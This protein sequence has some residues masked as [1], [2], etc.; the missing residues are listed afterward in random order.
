[1]DTSGAVP[2][3]R[4]LDIHN[5]DQGN[6]LIFLRRAWPNETHNT[7]AYHENGAI[8]FVTKEAVLPG[9]ELLYWP[10]KDYAALLSRL[11]HY[12]LVMPY[13]D[14]GLGQHWFR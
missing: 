4:T 10:S 5:E 7:V 11:T 3:V 1:M 13:G 12:G 6:W 14:I 8:Y 9:R 2:V